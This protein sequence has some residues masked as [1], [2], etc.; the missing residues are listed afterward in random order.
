MERCVQ[1]IRNRELDQA[2]A[3]F[4]DMATRYAYHMA[5]TPY[6][7]PRPK[8]RVVTKPPEPVARGDDCPEDLASH[9]ATKRLHRLQQ[10]CHLWEGSAHQRAIVQDLVRALRNAEGG[11]SEWTRLL[12]A[13][14]TKDD[15]QRLVD[16]ATE[17][18]QAQARVTQQARRDGWST[19]VQ[20][21]WTAGARRFLS[22]SD[23]DRMR[24]LMLTVLRG[25][26]QLTLRRSPRAVVLRLG[27]CTN[28]G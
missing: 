5:G 7:G 6:T 21:S 19:G 4:T 11:G 3:A 18:V 16:K 20:N 22:G 27:G 26:S 15:W 8:S 28:S 2:W 1:F 10:V 9:R 25:T 23:R 13:A 14:V 24:P 17:M 12:A